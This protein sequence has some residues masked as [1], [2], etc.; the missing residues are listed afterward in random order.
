M[1]F[2]VDGGFGDSQSL[3]TSPG[4]HP[5]QP[6]EPSQLANAGVAFEYEKALTLGGVTRYPDFTIEDEISGSTYYWEHLGMLDRA[7]YRRSWEKKLA[8]YRANDIVPV[9]DGGGTKGTLITTRESS[10]EPFD[11][12][13]VAKAVAVVAA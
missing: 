6:I 7:E 1:G 12:Q 8:W 5:Q 9:E 4:E 2:E 13:A 10:T 11:G 3:K